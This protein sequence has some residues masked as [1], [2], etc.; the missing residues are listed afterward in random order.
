MDPNIGDMIGARVR[1]IK[2]SYQIRSS[3]VMPAAP[4]AG[5]PALKQEPVAFQ[6]KEDE[7][8]LVAFLYEAFHYSL[9]PA[10]ALGLGGGSDGFRRRRRSFSAHLHG[11][12]PDGSGSC[13]AKIKLRFSRTLSGYLGESEMRRLAEEKIWRPAAEKLG[14][15]IEFDQ[16][17]CEDACYFAERADEDQIENE[18]RRFADLGSPVSDHVGVKPLLVPSHSAAVA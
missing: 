7:S 3:V 6:F 18:I 8:E 15:L 12:F 1:G 10:V 2:L 9:E 13:K 5:S 17:C 16:R 4:K 14:L 11:K